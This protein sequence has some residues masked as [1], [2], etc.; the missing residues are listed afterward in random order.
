MSTNFV[1]LPVES[2]VVKDTAIRKVDTKTEKYIALVNDLKI[3][4]QESPIVVNKVH[5]EETN[6][7]MFELIEGRHRLTALQELGEK[8]VLCDVRELTQEEA[9]GLQL[10]MNTIRIEQKKSEESAQLHRLVAAEGMTI[11][12]LAKITGK[13]VSTLRD[14]LK[15][16]TEHLSEKAVNL[17]DNKSINTNNALT[18]AK[19][20]KESQT[21]EL[22]Q[23]AQAM[24]T[25]QFQDHVATIKASLAKGEDPKPKKGPV[26]FEARPK[27]RDKDILLGEIKTG[28]LAQAKYID[29]GQQEAFIEGISYALSLDEETVTKAREEFELNQQEQARIKAQKEIAKLEARKAENEARIEAAKNITKDE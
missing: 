23:A 11:D 4:G 16:N 9:M 1:E 14:R 17:M 10:R 25:K 13:S 5:D 22:I 18:L 7:E 12:Q 26:E 27:F 20:P 3:N 6:T 19:L 24:P 8:Y 21:D 29:P 15:L 28:S 2:I